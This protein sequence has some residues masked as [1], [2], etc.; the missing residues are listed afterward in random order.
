MLDPSVTG[1]LM[2]QIDDNATFDPDHYID[3]D[4]PLRA[5]HDRGTSHLSVLADNG[6]AVALTSSVNS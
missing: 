4:A 2:E 5:A 6:D 3:S 1:T